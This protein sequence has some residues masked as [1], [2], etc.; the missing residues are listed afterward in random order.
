MFYFYA[1]PAE[2]FLILAVVYV[3]GC[4][5][6]PPPGAPRDE[7]RLVAGAV[8]AGSSCCWSRSTSPTSI[9]IYTGESIPTATG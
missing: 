2:P 3:L 8:V 4:I 5:M 6:T 1:L 9:P 7:N